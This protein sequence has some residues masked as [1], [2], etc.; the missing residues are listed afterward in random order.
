MICQ[1]GF[2]H[3]EQYFLLVIKYAC[4]VTCI[5]K[6][7]ACHHFYLGSLP[8]NLGHLYSCFF[9]FTQFFKKSGSRSS[10]SK[11]RLLA[12]LIIRFDGL[13]FSLSFTSVDVFCPSTRPL[14]PPPRNRLN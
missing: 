12:L 7:I 14:L 5:I 3:P 6:S 9:F 1:V 13:L 4:C 10:L 8:L 2:K 11:Q